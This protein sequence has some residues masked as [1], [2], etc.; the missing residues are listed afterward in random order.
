MQTLS[1]IPTPRLEAQQPALHVS[2]A[3]K[4]NY[5]RGC[6]GMAHDPGSCRQQERAAQS[7]KDDAKAILNNDPA[8]I[9]AMD[10]RSCT[11]EEVDDNAKTKGG[12]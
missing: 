5:S 6:L 2:M 9:G 11:C 12:C 4:T 1:E 7:V 10:V 8:R 3:I